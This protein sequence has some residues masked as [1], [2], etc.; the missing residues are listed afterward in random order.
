MHDPLVCDAPIYEDCIG[1]VENARSVL[2]ESLVIPSHEKLTS[3]QV[4]HIVDLV[5]QFVKVN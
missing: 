3:D 4:C 2:K 1:N 5:V